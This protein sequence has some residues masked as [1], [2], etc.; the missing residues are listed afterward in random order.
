MIGPGFGSVKFILS[1]T[2]I[3]QL[4]SV[5]NIASQRV[6]ISKK[7]FIFKR[8]HY[9]K[10]KANDSAIISIKCALPNSLRNGDFLGKAF[11]NILLTNF[12]LKFK[13]GQSNIKISNHTS[14]ALNIKGNTAL[15]SVSVDLVN[16]L[17]KGRKIITHYH[18]DLDGSLSFSSQEIAE[19]PIRADMDVKVNK[20]HHYSLYNNYNGKDL[21]YK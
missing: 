21:K 8:T 19:W 17:S 12:L 20:V 7:S 4:K 16:G 18:T 3:T 15:G 10:I 5:I 2:S 14:K 11:T 13:R 6:N 1:T 9:C